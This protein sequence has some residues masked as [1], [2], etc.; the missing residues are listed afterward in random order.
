MYM[1]LLLTLLLSF[2]L[3][4]SFAQDV[5]KE[6]S[7]LYVVDSIPVIDEPEEGLGT[8]RNGDVESLVVV[9]N[10][11]KVKQHGYPSVDKIIFITT[12]EYVKRP[13]DVKKIPTTKIMERKGN[14]WYLK[15][16]TTPYTGKFIDY[17]FN[18]KIQG[19][20]SMKN[21]KVDGLRTIYYANGNKSLFRN[22]VD[23]I[24]NGYS[25]EYFINGNI[26]QKGT[27]KDG[28]DE[29]V[30]QDFYSTGAIKRQMNFVNLKP[31]VT[32]EEEKFY[33]LYDQAR[34]LMSEYDY[35]TA[36]KKLDQAEKLNSN[37]ADIYFYRGT[38]KLNNFDF[39]NAILDFDKAIVLEPLYM[40]ALANRAFT[41]IR[42]HQFK[43]SRTLNKTSEVSVLAV[44][45]D[46]VIPADDKEKIC[47]D[48]N[49]S[50]DLGDKKAMIVDAIEQYCTK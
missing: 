32:K 24:A 39:D 10:P 38:A 48:L 14:V 21:G 19:E 36:I 46:I 33:S 23:G 22:Y 26:K 7:I 47:F 1:K 20:G 9:T 4:T 29:G 50:Y 28:K 2:S 5:K 15:G 12:K 8:M 37:Y 25:E 13:D 27:F 30:W 18:G 16:S 17:F 43:N 41:R 49:K 3:L 40:E 42:K 34:K 11:E 6:E 35:T 45:D 31:Q 44:K